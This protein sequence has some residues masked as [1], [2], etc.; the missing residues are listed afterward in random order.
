VAKPALPFAVLKRRL[1]RRLDAM[2]VKVNQVRLREIQCLECSSLNLT[3][4]KRKN[5]FSR[6]GKQHFVRRGGGPGAGGGGMA[7]CTH[8]QTC[9][10]ITSCNMLPTCCTTCSACV[11]QH[12]YITLLVLPPLPP[13][14][15]IHKEEYNYT[16]K[17]LQTCTH[18]SAHATANTCADTPSPHPPPTPNTLPPLNPPTP[19]IHEEEWSYIPVGG[20]L[21]IRQQPLTAFGAAANLVHPATGFSVS[22]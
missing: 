1:Q 15:E 20:P 5:M 14:Q 10:A 21:P 13:P 16:C 9:T 7:P 17:L 8:L 18:P 22:R 3:L 2:G 11:T 12:Q 19:Q 6:M 4:N